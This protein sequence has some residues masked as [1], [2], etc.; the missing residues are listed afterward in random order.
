MSR[1]DAK[2]WAQITS[3]NDQNVATHTKADWEMLHQLSSRILADIK[4]SQ[5]APIG[6]VTGELCTVYML[7]Q[8]GLYRVIE[9]KMAMED[10]GG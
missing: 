8:V 6:T 7:A 3:I 5:G 2:Q 1:P 9:A 4:A 10:D